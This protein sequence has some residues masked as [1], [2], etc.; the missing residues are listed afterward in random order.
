MKTTTDNAVAPV[1]AGTTDHES[2]N[3]PNA[4]LILTS[5]P[6]LGGPLKESWPLWTSTTN[7]DSNEEPSHQSDLA[8]SSDR[9]DQKYSQVVQARHN[10]FS[11]LRQGTLVREDS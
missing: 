3:A 5:L 9:L 11:F 4:V 8:L 10:Q 6:L 2:L 7:D 1:P